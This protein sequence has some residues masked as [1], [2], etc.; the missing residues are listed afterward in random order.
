MYINHGILRPRIQMKPYLLQNSEIEGLGVDNS[1]YVRNVH[2]RA[3]DIIN[4]LGVKGGG[5][6][7]GE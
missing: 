2:V 7:K 1:Y 4:D 5:G 6:R 3:R